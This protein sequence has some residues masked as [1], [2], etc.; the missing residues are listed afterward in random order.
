M[1][2][3]Q[4]PFD[5]AAEQALRALGAD[6]RADAIDAWS[7]PIGA[8]Q[9]LGGTGDVLV[10]RG[11]TDLSGNF[12]ATGP[13]PAA[14]SWI[15]IARGSAD[16]KICSA[17]ATCE[18]RKVSRVVVETAPLLDGSEGAVARVCL[19][20]DRTGTGGR[21]LLVGEAWARSEELAVGRLRSFAARLARAMS[22]PAS[23]PGAAAEE[24][25]EAPSEPV[26]HVPAG[27]LARFAL[28]SEGPC[29]VL[30]DFDS[31]GPKEGV[32]LHMLIAAVFG[33]GAAGAWTMFAKSGAESGYGAGMSL[34]W[35]GGS[36]LLTLATVAFLGVTRFALKYKAHSAPLVS[37]VAGKVTVAP[38]VARD[39]ALMVAPEGRFGAGIDLHEVR[40]VSMKERNGRFAVE[41]DTDHDPLDALLIDD[42][43]IAEHLAKALHRAIDDLRPIGGPSA[44]QRFRAR[45]QA[46][47]PPQPAMAGAK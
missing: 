14:P 22:V 33:A 17:E 23:L 21:K 16:V 15:R 13:A 5:L 3:Q 10:V 6:P 35:L 12:G 43:A 37:I 8:A 38:W 19:S 46:G 44:R 20:L 28:R 1:A 27:A 36:L 31:R 26:G 25:D 7:D 11:A 32:A 4:S 18:A 41:V 2:Q 40:G 30:R 47:G 39:G 45:A 29:L 24:I 34:A 42:R 9:A